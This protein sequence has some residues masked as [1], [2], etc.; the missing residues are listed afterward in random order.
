MFELA[1][2]IDRAKRTKQ[3]FV[4]AFVD[5]DHL[6]ATNDASGHIAGDDLLREVASAIRAHVRS[7]DLIVRFGG[8]EFVCGL[9]DVTLTEADNRFALVN[10][11]LA[12]A[13]HGSVS[14]GLTELQQ[15]DDLQSLVA[16][17]DE[18]MYEQR[19]ALRSSGRG[20]RFCRS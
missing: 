15:D 6:K 17:A 14:F 19:Q 3:Q 16:R 9:P 8:D 1:R 13:S 12:A 5:V 10:A 20:T 2:E 7:Y 4:L 11:R 18:A